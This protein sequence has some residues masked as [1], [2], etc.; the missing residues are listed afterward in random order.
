MM[1]SFSLILEVAMK[2]KHSGS[3]RSLRKSTKGNDLTRFLALFYSER[4]G[5]GKKNKIF[6]LST[7]VELRRKDLSD[8]NKWAN[9][10]KTF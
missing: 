7:S 10:E 3:S 4:G 9:K 6:N 2:L 8:E 5:R 1:L